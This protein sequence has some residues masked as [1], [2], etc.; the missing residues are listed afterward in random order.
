M[1]FLHC[2]IQLHF[3]IWTAFL[4][5]HSAT[6]CFLHSGSVGYK[7]VLEINFHLPLEYS[8]LNILVVILVRGF[9][10]G[11]SL[12]GWGGGG[13]GLKGGEADS[14][15]SRPGEGAG[16][17]HPSR[18]ARGYGERWKLPHRGLG[19]RPRSQCFLRWKTLQN[20]AKTAMKV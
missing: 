10:S 17:G 18:P 7:L 20:Y 5:E 8:S 3:R 13:G 6:S 2:S 4:E 1:P 16:G 9:T 14:K 11:S 19:L 15:R 12:D